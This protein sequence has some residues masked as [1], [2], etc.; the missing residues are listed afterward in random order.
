MKKRC[1][2]MSYSL[3][4]SCAMYVRY[5]RKHMDVPTFEAFNSKHYTCLPEHAVAFARFRSSVLSARRAE[6]IPIRRKLFSLYKCL[7][8]E[9]GLQVAVPT[10]RAVVDTKHLQKAIPE[11][12]PP[13]TR[14][15]R[16][17]TRPPVAETAAVGEPASASDMDESDAPEML[18]W[19]VDSYKQALTQSSNPKIKEHSKDMVHFIPVERNE[20]LAALACKLTKT[21]W[22]ILTGKS[23][24]PLKMRDG[25]KRSMQEITMDETDFA[26]FRHQR[27]T[28]VA[29][30]Y[31]I[32][33]SSI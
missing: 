32:R 11:V 21:T 13:L 23:S 22:N 2:K 26:E 5:C 18:E 30:P 14:A 29:G 27:K 9:D 25:S 15:V 24:S 19:T 28:K 16:L 10:R 4:E 33:V 31:F 6:G 17:N 3:H 20:D 7:V 8:G 1:K 12:V